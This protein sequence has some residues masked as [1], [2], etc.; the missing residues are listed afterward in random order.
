MKPRIVVL[1]GH[2]TAAEPWPVSRLLADRFDFTFAVTDHRAGDEGKA[3]AVVRSRRGLLPRGRAFDLATLVPGDGYRGLADA[4]RGAD[5]VHSVE[6]GPW[7]SGQAAH[8]RRALDFRLVVTVW[9]TIPLL[10]AYRRRRARANRAATLANTDLFLP[11]SERSAM[12]LRLEGVEEER[13]Q[14]CLPAVDTDTFAATRRRPV[15]STSPLIVSPGRLVWEKGHQDILRATALLHRGIVTRP[16]G[17]PVAPRVLIVGAGPEE[18]RLRLHAAELGIGDAVE[19]RRSVPNAEMAD[20]FAGAACIVLASLPVWHWEEQFGMVIA[21]AFAGGTPVVTTRS[22]AIPEVVG[23]SAL[24][25]DAGDFP[26]LARTLAEG[27]LSDPPR[28]PEVDPALVERYSMEAYAERL[29]AA[30]ERVLAQRR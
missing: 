1:H 29:A 6:V 7:Y 11:T 13:I 16:D 21:E 20:L 30:Y 19:F 17:K 27:P 10:D 2:H 8:L 28:V 5:I 23:D 22:G 25:V 18:A 4:L 12:A 26:A 9:E 15:D 24:L 3:A 14:V